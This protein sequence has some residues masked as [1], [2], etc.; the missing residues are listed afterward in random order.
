MTVAATAPPPARPSTPL[1]RVLALAAGLLGLVLVAQGAL[2]LLDLPPAPD[3][4]RRVLA[5][6]AWLQGA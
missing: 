1:R 5:V 6:L 2:T 4:N 3:D